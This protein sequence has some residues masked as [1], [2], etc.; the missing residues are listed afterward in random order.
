MAKSKEQKVCHPTY[1]PKD[2]A[3]NQTIIITKHAGV[4]KPSNRE[5][6]KK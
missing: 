1:K 3:N 6:I 2:T 5:N 4:N